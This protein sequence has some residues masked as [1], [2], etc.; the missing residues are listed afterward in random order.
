MITGASASS[1]PAVIIGVR[2]ACGLHVVSSST[3]EG[4]ISFTAI[5]PPEIRFPRNVMMRGNV[6][7]RLPLS[8]VNEVEAH[9]TARM[10]TPG[11]ITSSRQGLTAV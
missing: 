7:L 10:L 11:G 3:M 6:T 5:K 4:D 2:Q 1:D 9:S 8:T